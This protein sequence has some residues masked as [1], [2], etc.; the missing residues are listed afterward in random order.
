M[1]SAQTWDIAS[2]PEEAGTFGGECFRA[3]CRNVG[4]TWRHNKSERY[5]CQRCAAD[6]NLESWLKGEAPVCTRKD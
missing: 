3:F 5:Y 2:P 4:A 6:L 1:A